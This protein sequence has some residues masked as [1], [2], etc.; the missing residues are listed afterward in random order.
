MNGKPI[1]SQAVFWSAL[2]ILSARGFGFLVSV[3]LARLISPEEFGLIAMLMIFTAVGGSFVDSGFGS[4]LLQKQDATHLDECSIFY[5]NILLGM[6]MA[7]LLCLAAPWIAAF[8]ERPILVTLTRMLSLNLVISR[9]IAIADRMAL[10]GA[11]SRAMGAP[12]RATIPSPV[13]SLIV[14]S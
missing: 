1:I 6:V 3:V 13:I 4:A 7:A 8:Y 11:S 9:W 5:F 10:W 2:E 12:K 14:P